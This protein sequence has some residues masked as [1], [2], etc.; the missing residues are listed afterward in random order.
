MAEGEGTLAG[1][2]V[3]AYQLG[4]LIGAGQLA[5]VYQARH[6]AVPQPAALKIFM[7]GVAAN[8]A[9]MSAMHDI[10]SRVQLL[11][12]DYILPIHGFGQEGTLLYLSMPLMR[13]SLRAILQRTGYLPL[14][15]AVTLLRQIATGLAAAHAA[16]IVHRDLKPE[17]VLLNVAG[18]GFVSDF[19]VGRDLSPESVE[20]RSLGTLSSLIGTPAYMA[21]EQLRGQPADQRA[22]VYALGVIFYEML[23]GAP[24]Y[25]GNTIYDVAAKALTTPIPPLSQ[26]AAGINPLL[27]RAILRALARDPTERWPTVQRFIVGLNATL[28]VRPDAPHIPG[29]SFTTM[30]LTPQMLGEYAPVIG[31]EV[32]IDK[33]STEKFTSQP[34]AASTDESSGS[35]I[36]I[37]TPDLRLFRVDSRPV[38]PDD[39]RPFPLL[40]LCAALLL[41]GIVGIGGAL[42]A[43]AARSGVATPTRPPATLAPTHVIIGPLN[44]PFPTATPK[45]TATPRPK[46]TATHAPT[47]TP[48]A[49]ITPTPTDTPTT[50]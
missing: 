50:P 45:P 16:D 28:P 47:A 3:G 4:E 39:R 1:S 10:A 27:E 19:G 15:R 7:P 18:Q 46:P 43:N 21:P 20:R 31:D 13:E 12:A 2:R 6:P 24:P 14:Y 49:T 23:T 22:D 30:P 41:L 38:S 34:D 40:L 32:A 11:K 8:T 37:P 44:T 17:N 5:E 26:H 48:T 29:R 42:L 33:V 36:A 25:S 35:G 9:Y